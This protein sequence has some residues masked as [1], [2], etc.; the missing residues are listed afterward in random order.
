V[1]DTRIRGPGDGGALPHLAAA[2]LTAVVG[3][4][5][6]VEVAWA[7]GAL[8]LVGLAVGHR[9]TSAELPAVPQ[10]PLIAATEARVAAAA[11]SAAY[12]APPPTVDT[13][14][15]LGAARAALRATTDEGRRKLDDTYARGGTRRIWEP[16]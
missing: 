8:A 14:A 3:I 16:S 12:A 9:R 10:P 7:L 13:A 11:P 1:L 5:G 2:V 6:W 4:A 15:A